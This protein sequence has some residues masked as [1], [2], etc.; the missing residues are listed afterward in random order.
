MTSQRRCIDNMFSGIEKRVKKLNATF[1][2]TELRAEAMEQ[3]FDEY[4][5]RIEKETLIVSCLDYLRTAKNR[6]AA[7]CLHALRSYL[8][9]ISVFLRE[10]D[11]SGIRWTND[12]LKSFLQQN[13]DSS[14]EPLQR[15]MCEHFEITPNDMLLLSSVANIVGWGQEGW[16]SN[17]GSLSMSK[18]LADI[19]AVID[20]VAEETD[21]VSLLKRIIQWHWDC[22]TSD[23]Y[24]LYSPRCCGNREDEPN[25]DHHTR[26]SI[27][28]SIRNDFASDTEHHL[29]HSIVRC[30]H[31]SDARSQHVSRDYTERTSTNS[32]CSPRTRNP[33]GPRSQLLRHTPRTPRDE[34]ARPS[35]E[36][37]AHTPRTPRDDMDLSDSPREC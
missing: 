1:D 8:V 19:M 25:L 30:K 12:Q 26:Y 35:R 24:G 33:Y 21:I 14:C 37:G 36:Q 28:C 32:A 10:N 22:C 29:Q 13:G 31:N 11:S 5:E 16:E 6:Y 3:R 2:S 18:E 4:L 20:E 27:D 7:L 17:M 15:R 23:V 34:V 9:A